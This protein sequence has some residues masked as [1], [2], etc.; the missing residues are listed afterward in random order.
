[1]PSRNVLKPETLERVTAG[2]TRILVLEYFEEKG[3]VGNPVVPTML[4]LMNN[5]K[6]KSII[7]ADNRLI[8]EIPDD[9]VQIR[10]FRS[11]VNDRDID[12]KVK[13]EEWRSMPKFDSFR[14]VYGELPDF[15]SDT[16][17][18]NS[19]GCERNPFIL[20]F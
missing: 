10:K 3:K 4:P 6:V 17:G 16:D 13:F 20:K 12:H 14:V 15:Y 18:K 8:Y 7:Q 11:M 5:L 9:E 1:M 2:E 19:S